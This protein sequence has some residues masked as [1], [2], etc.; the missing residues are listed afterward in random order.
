MPGLRVLRKPNTTPTITPKKHSFV[1][2]LSPG[3]S[4]D[5]VTIAP[6]ASGSFTGSS[7]LSIV[8]SNPSPGTA[9]SAD[10]I[11]SLRGDRNISNSRLDYG[12]QRGKMR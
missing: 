1:T 8:T 7:G 9:G 3:L 12:M 5:G 2:K 11:S 6:V 10:P 4:N